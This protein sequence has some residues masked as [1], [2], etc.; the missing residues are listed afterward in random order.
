MEG[1]MDGT[2]DDFDTLANS[3]FNTGAAYQDANLI[4][5]QSISALELF[6]KGLTKK[7]LKVMA[8]A[9]V[10]SVLHQANPLQVAEALTAMETFCKE[11][12][13][14]KAFKDYVREE[15]SKSPKGFISNSGAKIEL[16]EVGTSYDF[17]GCNDGL[18][19]TLEEE[20]KQKA[21]LLD[22]RKKFLKTVPASGLDLVTPD[23]E[24][25]KIYPPTKTSTS[26]YK[27]TLAK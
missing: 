4:E 13:D 16:T 23:G 21:D 5:Q 1:F 14:T 9:A 10:E 11:V 17:S 7:D 18:L 20:L 12:K 19:L 25:I 22:E 26:S 24:V 15:A 2:S 3:I 27:I 8:A 6:E